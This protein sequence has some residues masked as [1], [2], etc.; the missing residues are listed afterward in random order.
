MKLFKNLHAEGRTIVFVT[1][2]INLAKQANR[3]I[4]IKDGRL[5]KQHVKT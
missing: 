4:A 2:D 5:I 1:H 3:I